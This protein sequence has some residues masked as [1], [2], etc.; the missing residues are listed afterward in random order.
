M[1]LAWTFSELF[2]MGV[3]K[4]VFG[5]GHGDNRLNVGDKLQIEDRST[6][7]DVAAGSSSSTDPSHNIIEDFNFEAFLNQDE[8]SPISDKKYIEEMELQ[9]ALMITNLPFIP[10]VTYESTQVPDKFCGIC[11]D[12]KREFEIF[13]ND[14]VCGHTFCIDCIRAHVGAKINEN[15]ANVRCPDP[16]CKGLIGPN[17]CRYIRPEEVLERWEHALCES[18]IIAS[19]K[20]YC[21]FKDCSAPLLVDDSAVPT[22]DTECPHCNRMFCAQ[23]KVPWHSE[24]DCKEFQML[25]KNGE[26]NQSDMK[27]RELA[28]KKKWQRCPKCN[29]Y[30]A[31]TVGCADINFAMRVEATEANGHVETSQFVRYG[32]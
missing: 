5:N 31:R 17:V 26:I 29:Y 20:L 32:S 25:S 28:K 21:P 2:T 3:L 14:N 30:V 24:M 15:V 23:C 27:V 1:S 8:K 11:M 9:E 18:L 19:Q 10:Y 13:I 16:D 6:S 22:K 12:T 7:D 4:K